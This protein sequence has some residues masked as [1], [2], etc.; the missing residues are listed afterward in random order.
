MIFANIIDQIFGYLCLGVVG[1]LVFIVFALYRI[2]SAVGSFFKSGVGQEV[3]KEV[4]KEV[5]RG[6]IGDIFESFVD[7]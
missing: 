3:A 5:T 7:D 2:G 4:G 6:V 1:F